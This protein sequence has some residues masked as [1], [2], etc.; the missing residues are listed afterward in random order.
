[1]EGRSSIAAEVARNQVAMESIN[2]QMVERVTKFT[3]FDAGG[4]GAQTECFS[5]ISKCGKRCT[6]GRESGNA[7]RTMSYRTGSTCTI[8]SPPA[9]YQDRMSTL[10][11][12]HLRTFVR[13]APYSCRVG[14]RTRTQLLSTTRAKSTKATKTPASKAPKTSTSS[15]PPSQVEKETL[16][17][18]EYLSIRKQKRRWETVRR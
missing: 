2:M 18:Q 6:A 15:A 1:M 16:P 12:P 14:A 5:T 3:Q 8:P 17:W 9:V 11:H 13:N 4:F 7:V 10:S